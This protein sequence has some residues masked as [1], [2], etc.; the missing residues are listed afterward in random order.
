MSFVEPLDSKVVD[1]YLQTTG[2]NVLRD[3]AGDFLVIFAGTEKRPEMQIAAV[4]R[5]G[6]PG[7]CN[8]SSRPRAVQCRGRGVV[9]R[10]DQPLE[11]RIPVA[12]GGA[13]GKPR[14]TVRKGVDGDAASSHKWRALWTHR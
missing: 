6:Q 8:P 2:Y 3:Q 12:K 4:G 11:P 9:A 7:L 13:W 5:E 1:Q 14:R 10:P